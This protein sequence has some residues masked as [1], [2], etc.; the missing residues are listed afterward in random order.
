MFSYTL[1]EKKKAPLKASTVLKVTS[2]PSSSTKSTKTPSLGPHRKSSSKL[3]PPP[4]RQNKTTLPNSHHDY[5][6]HTANLRTGM[7]VKSPSRLEPF[8][9][10]RNH[11]FHRYEH[12]FLELSRHQTKRKELQN[13]LQIDILALRAWLND[14]TFRDKHLWF[15]VIQQMC[16]HLATK[17]TC[18]LKHFSPFQSA[19]IC[20]MRNVL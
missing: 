6:P 4:P 16:Y 18:F 20:V 13:Y 1:V 12:C 8:R 11:T 15:C 10:G 7:L 3:S 17:T 5:H 2:T 14:R 19:K 9:T